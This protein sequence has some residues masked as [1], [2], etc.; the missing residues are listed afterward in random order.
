MK[1][2]PLPGHGRRLAKAILRSLAETIDESFPGMEQKEKIA[3]VLFTTQLLFTNSFMAASQSREH[4]LQ[5]IDTSV[6]HIKEHI[7]K[8]YDYKEHK[9]DPTRTEQ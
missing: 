6:Q 9:D 3:L 8:Y 1:D 4:A 5:G 2:D 7:N